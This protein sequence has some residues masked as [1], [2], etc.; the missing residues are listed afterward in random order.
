[1]KRSV[2]AF[3]ALAACLTASSQSIPLGEI[4]GD[5][6]SIQDTMYGLSARYP[7]SWMVR[8]VTRWGNRETTIYLGVPKLEN[9]FPTIYYRMFATSAPLPPN[10][11]VALREEAKLRASRRVNGGLADYAN[12]PDSFTF[13]NINGH[14]AISYLA[15]YTAGGR[16]MCEYWVRVLSEKG[17][18]QFVLRAPLEDIDA[19]RGDFE[20]MAA[21]L[22]FP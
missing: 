8:G 20:A 12:D 3:A 17:V 19:L 7:S 6:H 16:T 21:S 1:M 4:I 22:R 5:D 15:K 9:S 14:P 11:E 10:A 2:L 13:K 18:A